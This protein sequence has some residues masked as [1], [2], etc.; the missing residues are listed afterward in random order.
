MMFEPTD[1]FDVVERVGAMAFETL[2][3][4]SMFPAGNAPVHH[5]E[6]HHVVTGGGLVA[7]RAVFRRR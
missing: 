5:L 1:S 6:M 4:L 7:L 2:V 3:H